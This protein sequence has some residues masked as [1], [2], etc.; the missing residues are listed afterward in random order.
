MNVEVGELCD[1]LNEGGEVLKKEPVWVPIQ[2]GRVV[3][4]AVYL[5]FTT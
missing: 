3:A 5:P 1:V 2:G 4:G